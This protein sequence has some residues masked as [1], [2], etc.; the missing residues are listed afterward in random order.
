MN[1]RIFAAVM[2]AQ[3]MDLGMAVMTGRD[4]V[5]RSCRFN[6][7]IFNFSISQTLF[8]ESGLQK[9]APAPAAKVVGLVGRHVDKV[10]FSDNRL[11]YKAEII[12]NGIPVRFS[13]DLTGILYGE[14]NFE[15]LVPVGIDLQFPFPDPFCIV[16]VNI[17]NLEIVFDVESFQS[18]QD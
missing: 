4:A 7:A 6:L 18:C 1:H 10:F 9:A 16:F 13:D 11:D 17:F 12:G 2:F 15:I 8:L 14:F 3:F 5:I